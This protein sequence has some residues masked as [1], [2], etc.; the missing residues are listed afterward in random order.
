M[1]TDRTMKAVPLEDFPTGNPFHHDALNVGMRL[2]DVLLGASKKE[3]YV[4][5]YIMGAAFQTCYDFYI[6]NSKTGE[7]I[8]IK[9]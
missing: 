5:C 7:R 1:G 8:G 2:T 4:G 9:L 3:K 6:V